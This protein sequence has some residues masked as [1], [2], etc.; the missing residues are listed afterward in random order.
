MNMFPFECYP[1]SK[2]SLAVAE[3]VCEARTN[4]ERIVPKASPKR[5]AGPAVHRNVSLEMSPMNNIHTLCDQ[6]GSLADTA[7][8]CLAY[9]SSGIGVDASRLHQ[10]RV[11]CSDR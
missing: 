11:P 10:Q 5:A 6:A 8:R 7:E 1:A 4:Q 3:A 2:P 9:G